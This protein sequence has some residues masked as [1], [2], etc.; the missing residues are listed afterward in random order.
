MPNVQP[1]VTTTTDAIAYR[2]SL[3]AIDPRV[4]YLMTLYLTP[5]LSPNDIRGA[6]EAGITG[7]KLYPRGV[8]THSDEGIDDLEPLMPVFAAMEEEGVVLE[9]HPESPSDPD[10]DVCI[11]NAEEDF[12]P[13]IG[14]VHATFPGL[15]IVVEHVTTAGAVAFVERLGDTVAATVTAHHLDLII[16]DWA[17]RNHNYCKPVAKYPHDRDALRRVVRDG[18]PSFFLGSDSAPHPRQAKECASGCAGVFTS[19]LLLAYIADTFERLD[20]LDRLESFVSEYG[21]QFYE[22]PPSSESVTI[23]RRKQVVPDAYG[24]AVPYRA[25]E[26]LNWSISPV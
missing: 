13:K 1:P 7:V 21:R 12:L 5:A 4:E 14:H 15:R 20:M 25:G 2:D 3:K 23:T 24:S 9:V 18:H 22:L 6:A 26:T 17:G 16:D 11:M 10:R 19:P 8:T